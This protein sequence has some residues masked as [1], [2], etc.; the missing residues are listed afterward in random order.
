MVRHYHGFEAGLWYD[1]ETV[2]G[3]TDTNAPF[4]HLAQK[5]EVKLSSAPAPN[6]VAKSGDV[7]NAAINKGIERPVATVTF[8]P[9][10]ASGAAF[11]KNFASSNTSF[12]LLIMIDE[13]SD[14][15]FARI[16]GCKVKRITV[17]NTLWPEAGPV[18]CVAEIWGWTILYVV[19]AGTPTFEAAPNSA[20]NWTD[21]TIKRNT[22]TITD[23]WNFEFTIDNELERSTDE[24]GV[25]DAITR[26]R[27]AVTGTWQRSSNAT[28]GVGDTEFDESRDATDVDLQMALSADTYDFV[29]SVYEEVE[30]NH[31]INSMVGIRG[32]FIAESL[33]IA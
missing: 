5:S 21:V 13:A 1:G 16:T 27:R 30:V 4:L 15:I 19:S 6:V 31:P 23:W 18:E 20:L 3:T 22:V 32:N 8:N 26:G 2:E 14:V 29:N 7:D 17:S 11:I 28:S 24:N 12:T 10:S 25:T 33:T 9:S